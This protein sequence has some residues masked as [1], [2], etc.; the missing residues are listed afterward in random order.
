MIKHTATFQLREDISSEESFEFFEAIY[1]L[2]NITG[3]Q[4][5]EVL[6]RLET[7]GKSEYGMFMRFE[8][9]EA[10]NL[11]LV[12]PN[13]VLFVEQ[14]WNKFVSDFKGADYESI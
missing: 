11:Y 3:V 12:H 7:A 8:N 14:Y 2:K 13:H 10:C 6:K 9:D 1:A 5:F 4:E